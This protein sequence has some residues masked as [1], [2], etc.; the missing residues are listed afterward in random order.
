MSKPL[1]GV[2]RAMDPLVRLALKPFE[3]LLIRNGVSGEQ[4]AELLM[5]R[6]QIEAFICRLEDELDNFRRSA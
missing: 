4:V 1:N 2:C 5:N 3:P 6:T